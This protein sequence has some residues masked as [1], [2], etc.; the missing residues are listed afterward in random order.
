[1]L[2]VG[3]GEKAFEVQTG[4]N[5]GHEGAGAVEE[6]EKAVPIDGEQEGFVRCRERSAFGKWNF[7][8]LE[9]VYVEP[10]YGIGGGEL[11][12]EDEFVA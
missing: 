7:T 2:R 4:G 1:M 3:R 6:R 10:L 5:A 8:A 11:G 9:A 12:D